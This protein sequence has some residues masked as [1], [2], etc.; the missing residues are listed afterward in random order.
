MPIKRRAGKSRQFDEYR[1]CQLLAGPD[2]TLLA[3]VGYLTAAR[4]ELMTEADQ[5]AA[6][7]DMRADWERH[8]AELLAWW[9]GDDEAFRFR[10]WNFIIRDPARLPW[11]AEQF[12]EPRETIIGRK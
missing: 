9:N 10:P 11:A 8:G 3:G 6:L 4:F 12:G 1:A 2:A 7:A 5:A